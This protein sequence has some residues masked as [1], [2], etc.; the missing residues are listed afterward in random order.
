MGPLPPSK[1]QVKFLVIAIY[2]FTKWVEA[3]PLEIITGAKIQ[4]FLWKNLV[5]QFGIPRV[6]ISDNG[7]QFDSHKFRD[8]CKELGIRNHYSS[9]GHPQANGQNEVTNQTLLKLIKTQLEGAKEAW[10]DE[11]PGVF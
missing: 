4:H 3:E 6:I 7:W 8:F 5:C 11:L 2:Y 1:K 10:T 9:P